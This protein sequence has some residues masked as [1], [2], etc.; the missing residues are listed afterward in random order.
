MQIFGNYPNSFFVGKNL[1]S[2]SQSEKKENKIEIGI[3]HVYKTLIDETTEYCI[4]ASDGIWDVI[5]PMDVYKICKRDNNP[6]IIVES[7]VDEAIEKGS[8]DNI[9]CIVICLKEGKK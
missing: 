1:K 2:I 4:I 7:I 5:E 3:G 8:E 6:D 9:S